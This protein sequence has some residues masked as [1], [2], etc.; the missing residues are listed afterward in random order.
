MFRKET[1]QIDF[2]LDIINTSKKTVDLYSNLDVKT[3]L[4]LLF[5][6]VAP[7][8]YWTEVLFGNKGD[9]E[10]QSLD[11]KLRELPVNDWEYAALEILILSLL[12]NS[13]VLKRFWTKCGTNS[14]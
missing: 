4:G 3:S 13:K 8:D 12:P 10:G 9:L 2:S 5:G 6:V 7:T 11:S 1:Y 14:T